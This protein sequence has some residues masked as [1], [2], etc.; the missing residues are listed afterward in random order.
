MPP[1]EIDDLARLLQDEAES[2]QRLIDD[3]HALQRQIYDQLRRVQQPTTRAP[4]LP[5]G[6][7][8]GRR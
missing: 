7:R 8:E 5:N 4:H 3:A 2:L 1:A 6:D